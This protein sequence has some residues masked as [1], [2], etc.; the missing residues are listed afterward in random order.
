MAA[1]AAAVEN[2]NIVLSC[3][4]RKSNSNGNND[5]YLICKKITQKNSKRN[6][7][8][9][10]KN[11]RK[12]NLYDK[13]VLIKE[14]KDFMETIDANI[15]YCLSIYQ[16]LRYSV[17]NKFLWDFSWPK[18]TPPL[19]T[20]IDKNDIPYAKCAIALANYI[21]NNGFIIKDDLFVY[22]SLL[23]FSNV[24]KK[25]EYRETIKTLKEGDTTFFKGLISTSLSLN[26]II[27]KQKQNLNNMTKSNNNV[28]KEKIIKILL[29]AG[30]R[31]LYLN[32][33]DEHEI[34]LA[35]GTLTKIDDEPTK[36][37]GIFEYTINAIFIN[38]LELSSSSSNA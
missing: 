9:E 7:A 36:F 18:T 30:T 14:L 11:T 4:K 28:S 10:K 34:L 31:I 26:T 20:V 16:G 21:L 15:K 17:I 1:A 22:R 29:P 3:K 35:P 32:F 19:K 37:L 33:Q 13:Q 25:K 27:R 8:Q 12:N 5:D 24:R 38:D 6:N 23:Y 2:N